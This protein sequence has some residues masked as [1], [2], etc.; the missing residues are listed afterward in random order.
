MLSMLLAQEIAD[1]LENI[2]CGYFL[3]ARR[4]CCKHAASGTG[5]KTKSMLQ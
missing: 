2:M 1:E 4:S 3:P 5:I